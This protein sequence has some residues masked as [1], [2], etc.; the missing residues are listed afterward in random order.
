MFLERKQTGAALSQQTKTEDSACPP[1][2]LLLEKCSECCWERIITRN[3]FIAQM[4][5]FGSQK[6]G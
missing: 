4:L 2:F 3:F 6:G 5:L 1:H